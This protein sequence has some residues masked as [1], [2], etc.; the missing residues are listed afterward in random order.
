MFK[1]KKKIFAV[2]LS[3]IVAVS[4]LGMVITASAAN[5]GTV[6]NSYKGTTSPKYVFL[7]I[8]DGMSFVQV[9]SAEDYLGKA[10]YEEKQVNIRK[11]KFSKFPV[12]G[13]CTTFDATSFCPDSA[14][15]ATSIASGK[16]TLSGV[17]N[18]DVT[19]QVK[20]DTI[21]ELLKAKGYKIGVVS[22][23]SLDHATPAA[24][25]AHQPTRSNMYEIALEMSASGFDYFGG[26]GIVYPKGKKGDQQDALEIA[27]N[28]GYTVV[29]DKTSIL[30][31]N[32]SSGKV[33]AINSV[34]D[35][36]KALPYEI[37]RSSTDLSLADFTRKGIDV[38][39]NSKGFFM[40]VEGGKIDWSCHAND[41]ATA[42]KDTLAFEKAVNEAIE[43]YNEHPDETL[44][45]VTGDHETGGMTIGWAGTG[46]STYFDKISYQKKSYIEFDK[47]IA[48]YVA[49]TAK[50][51]AKLEDLLPEIKENFGL[52]VS[53]DV[54]AS[55][56]T[57]MVLTAYEVQRLRD[58][59]AK[60]VLPASERKLSEAESIAYGYYNPF[61]VTLTHIL[62][63]KSGIGWTS[64]SHT[65]VP[66][67]V[68]AK[69]I[70]MEVFNGYYDNTD[71]CKKL[72]S[73][74]KIN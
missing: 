60:S 10:Y 62:N 29:N 50:Q 23:V 47:I 34:L 55:S 6:S 51:D 9:N 40:M 42:I 67:P 66:V 35:K 17:I 56:R 7:F 11:L 22:S 26:G 65:G 12:V 33:I 73:I 59:L 53:S 1:A 36:D 69:G 38:L 68:Y 54:D 72:K 39:E 20:F 46:Y 19:K 25:Y 5:Q 58:A 2:V 45:I 37:D 49:K 70:G 30:N 4:I 13:T 24:F 31:L 63:N 74:M 61:S 52:V 71:I 18:M 41:A 8:G 14:S 43:F 64:Y 28:K 32:S 21:A 57:G 44:I 48:Q 16:K 15:T 27:A 3:L